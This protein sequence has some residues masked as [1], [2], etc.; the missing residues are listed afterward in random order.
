MP[1]P[2]EAAVVHWHRTVRD[3][4]CSGPGMPCPYELAD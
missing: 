1:C 2:Y 3:T 4:Q